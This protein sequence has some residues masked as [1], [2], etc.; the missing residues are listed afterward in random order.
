[1]KVFEGKRQSIEQMCTENKVRSL[2]VFGS[3]V[4]NELTE[5]SDIDLLVDIESTDPFEYTDNY[6]NLLE[7]LQK[8]LKRPIDLLESRGLKNRFLK[9]EIDKTKVPLYG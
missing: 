9:A 5:D 4:R 8:L 2:F 7:Q 6:F 1:M 3:A